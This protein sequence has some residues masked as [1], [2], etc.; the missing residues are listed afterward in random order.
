MDN[1]VSL[2]RQVY[3][4]NEGRYPSNID[5]SFIKRYYL[6]LLDKNKSLD[7]IKSKE[8]RIID[9]TIEKLFIKYPEYKSRDGV[10]DI[11]DSLTFLFRECCLSSVREN[12][13][14]LKDKL[15][16]ILDLFSEL[17]FDNLFINETFFL[18]RKTAKDEL[19][20]KSY[21]DTES[22]L[23][24]LSTD[25]IKI[26]DS[27]QK[28]IDP[29]SVLV[30]EKIYKKYPD[31]L[32]K[33]TDMSPK[34]DVN[35]I[36]KQSSLCMLTDNIF[37]FKDQTWL[38]INLF[39][40]LQITRNP[41][42]DTMSLIRD[43][44]QKELDFYEFMYLEKFLNIIQYNNFDDYILVQKSLNKVKENVLSSSNYNNANTE[45][46]YIEKILENIIMSILTDD[47]GYFKNFIVNTYSALLKEGLDDKVIDELFTNMSTS[48]GDNIDRSLLEKIKPALK[49]MEVQR[50]KI[51]QT[52]NER[53]DKVIS[54]T[55]ERAYLK[56][57]KMLKTN[58]KNKD[59]GIRD[60]NIV[61]EECVISMMSGKEERLKK[62]VDY[63]SQL[64]SNL[65]FESGFIS[66]TFQMLDESLLRELPPNVYTA[67][68]PH[69]KIAK[70][71]LSLDTK[72]FNN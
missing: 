8:T 39:K 18:L 27:I 32:L 35:L 14:Y 65:N 19:S 17:G 1:T 47:L 59:L 61:L 46:L 38:L 25:K 13:E 7:E 41:V 48:F 34:M 24:L 55:N 42:A 6:S 10:S 23:N 72:T 16:E 2:I 3:K 69:I 40:D 49:M 4:N 36:L 64:F 70:T 26:F 21:L 52:I 68:Q 45:N 43:I 62:K 33:D 67:L 11:E 22:Y 37:L 9:K 66:D 53:R 5:E 71:A 15:N 60:L 58:T 20:Y 54:Q 63:M 28:K 44:C 51:V 30:S 12:Q 31:M 57:P 50:I 56:Y 29:I